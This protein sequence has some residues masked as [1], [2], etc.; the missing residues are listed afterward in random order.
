[1]MSGF[2]GLFSVGRHCGRGRSS[3]GSSR[4][5]VAPMDRRSRGHRGLGPLLAL[6]QGRLRPT[7]RERHSAPFAVPRGRVLLLG[8]PCASS[9]PRGRLRPRLERRPPERQT[10]HAT[11]AGGRRLRRLLDH[12]DPGPTA[13][14]TRWCRASARAASC[15][16]GSALAAAGFALAALAPV[17][18]PVGPG[19]RPRRRGRLERRARAVLGGGSPAPR[20]PR[21][22]AVAAVTTLGYAGHLAGPALIGFAARLTTSPSRCSSWRRC[23]PSWRCSLE[24]SRTMEHGTRSV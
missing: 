4:A 7:A 16:A 14:A 8:A 9:F 11:K 6:A 12:D 15:S 2:H 21:Q 3:R 10:R 20:C 22:P 17:V 19:V 1:M 18:A 5:G 23:W 13:R 24:R